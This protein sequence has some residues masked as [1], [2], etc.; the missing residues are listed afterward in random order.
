MFK[1]TTNHESYKTIRALG[2]MRLENWLSHWR[3][4][5]SPRQR[6]DIFH[7]LCAIFPAQIMKNWGSL[8]PHSRLLFIKWHHFILHLTNKTSHFYAPNSKSVSMICSDNYL[9]LIGGLFSDSEPLW[10]SDAMDW[11]KH[12]WS[13]HFYISVELAFTTC[14]KEEMLFQ[15][16][17]IL[18]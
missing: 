5:C 17:V 2:L 8:D 14:V 4:D 9:L 11:H 10:L 7:F 1:G 12:C 15:W 13:V 16:Q 6:L 3:I 18:S